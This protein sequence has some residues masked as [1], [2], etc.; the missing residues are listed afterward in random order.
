M[1][2]GDRQPAAHGTSSTDRQPG[3]AGLVLIAIFK[4]A[5]ALALITAGVGA[6]RLLDPRFAARVEGWLTRVQ[7]AP[8]RRIVAFLAGANER[9]I[10]ELGIVLFAYALVFLIEG[11]GLLMRKRWA[12]WFTIIVTASLL[13]FEIYEL[14]KGVS[15][16]KIIAIVIN[17]AVVVYLVMRVVNR[18][19]EYGARRTDA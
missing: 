2:A 4:L 15:A 13:P 8:G 10:E 7:L 19:S 5:K 3:A 1:R 17:V 12:E 18:D 14:A 9:K 11:G 6:L 16:A